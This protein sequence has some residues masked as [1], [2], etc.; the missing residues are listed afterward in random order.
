MQRPDCKIYILY[1]GRHI[2]AINQAN[3]ATAQ[4]SG[5]IWHLKRV[6]TVFKGTEGCRLMS[7]SSDESTPP[8]G[9]LFPPFTGYLR[10]Y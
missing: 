3:D 7:L 4:E 5:I 8:T 6:K 9:T 1:I 10:A 2:A